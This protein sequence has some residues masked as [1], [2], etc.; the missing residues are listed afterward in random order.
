ML[1]YVGQSYGM[2]NGDPRVLSGNQI[3]RPD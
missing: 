1:D 2:A 3:Y